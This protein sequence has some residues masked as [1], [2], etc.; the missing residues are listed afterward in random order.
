MVRGNQICFTPSPSRGSA[1]AESS[2]DL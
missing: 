1:R 2:T